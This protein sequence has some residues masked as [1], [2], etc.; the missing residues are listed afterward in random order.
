MTHPLRRSTAVRAAVLVVLALATAACGSTTSPSPSS[1]SAASPSLAA[2]SGGDACARAGV[3]ATSGGWGGGAGSRGADVQVTNTGGAPCRL[4]P[5]PAVVLL[6]ANG[7]SVLQST[8]AVGGE[9]ITLAPGGAASFSFITA[10]W[11]DPAVA[12]PVRPSVV[13]TAEAVAISDLP[14]ATIDDLP[15]CIGE[16]QPATISATDWEIQPAP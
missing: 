6:D 11:C 8:P 14:V 2:P 5:R 7:V 16:G 9:P 4:P 15:A 3:A 13:L 12:L 1:P 10:N